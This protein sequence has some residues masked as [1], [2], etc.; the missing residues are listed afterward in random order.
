MRRTNQKKG[1]RG[2]SC[3]TVTTLQTSYKDR[4]DSGDIILISFDTPSSFE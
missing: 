3:V 1:K 4:M 2:S